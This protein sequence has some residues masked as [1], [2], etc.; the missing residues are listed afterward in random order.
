[1]QIRSHVDRA[2]L[3]P[4]EYILESTELKPVRGKGMYPQLRARALERYG[5]TSFFYGAGPGDQDPFNANRTVRLH[6]DHIMPLSQGGTDAPDNLRVLC[7]ACNQGRT[8]VLPLT[9]NARNIIARI[10]KLSRADQKSA[11]D[12]LRRR[13][14]DD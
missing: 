14:G 6:V 11:L 8:N 2:D 4:N 10:R 13:F 9:E 5:Y 1:M 7:S 12:F 3:K